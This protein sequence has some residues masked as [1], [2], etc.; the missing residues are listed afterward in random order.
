MNQVGGGRG[1]GAADNE[2]I[3]LAADGAVTAVPRQSKDALA[4]FVLALVAARLR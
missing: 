3:V 1:F 2:W 4:D